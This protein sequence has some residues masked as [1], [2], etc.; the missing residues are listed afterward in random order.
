MGMAVA[1]LNLLLFVVHTEP[2]WLYDELVGRI[3]SARAA[4][5]RERRAYEEGK[6]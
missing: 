6:S 3:I 1:S 5:K 4:T 2:I